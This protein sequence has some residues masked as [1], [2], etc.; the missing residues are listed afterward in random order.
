[1]DTSKLETY[2]MEDPTDSDRGETVSLHGQVGANYTL[3]AVLPP[4]INLRY[5]LQHP[6]YRGQSLDATS[7]KIKR[8]KSYATLQKEY[9]PKIG[10]FVRIYRE[11]IQGELGYSFTSLVDYTQSVG[12][13][14]IVDDV[15]PI[16][17][18][19]INGGYYP[20]FIFE[21]LDKRDFEGK[22]CK[23]QINGNE[24]E[25]TVYSIFNCNGFT[26][27]LFYYSSGWTTRGINGVEFVKS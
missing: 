20:F 13:M 19:K 10:D 1:M 25:L 26:L 11:P 18:I 17:G 16:N 12:H 3:L 6:K 22:T 4:H 24:K 2:T 23:V 21:T 9:G 14:G 27:C 15:C 5:I 8:K 7:V